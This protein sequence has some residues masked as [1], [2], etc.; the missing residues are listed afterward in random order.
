MTNRQELEARA[1]QLEAELERRKRPSD[2]QAAY[3]IDNDN[4]EEDDRP[5]EEL[6]GS[7][8]QARAATKRQAFRGREWSEVR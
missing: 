7:E 6:T 5:V 1:A 3:A 4:R 2:K 8:R